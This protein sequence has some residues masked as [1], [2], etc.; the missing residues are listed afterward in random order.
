MIKYNLKC[1]N[2]HEFESWFS[3]SKEFDKLKKNNLLECIF[4]SSKKIQKSI[5][6][7]MV[8]GT[9]IKDE[10]KLSPESEE[11]LIKAVANA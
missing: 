1:E 9:K 8:S 7:P 2:N 6:S 3:H 4:C 10:Q 11:L 5:M